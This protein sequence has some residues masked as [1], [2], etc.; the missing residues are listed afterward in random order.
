MV[1]HPGA[2]LGVRQ[3]HKNAKIETNKVQMARHELI[4][5]KNG[6]GRSRMPLET[7][8]DRFYRK[9][10]PNKMEMLENRKID[11]PGGMREALRITYHFAS[12]NCGEPLVGWGGLQEQS[13]DPQPAPYQDL[14]ESRPSR[15][16]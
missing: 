8:T 16:G 11:R 14:G 9:T 4:L 6:A 5:R 1:P 12:H 15:F 13:G 10:V 7:C 2:Q 3:S